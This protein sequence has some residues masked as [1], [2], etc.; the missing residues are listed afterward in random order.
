MNKHIIYNILHTKTSDNMN[1]MI[2]HEIFLNNK[3]KNI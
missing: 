1:N 2:G 3:N